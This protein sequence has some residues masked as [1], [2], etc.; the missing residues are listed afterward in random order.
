[1]LDVK[2]VILYTDV[3]LWALLAVVLLYVW[4]VRREPGLAAKWRRV[5]AGPHRRCERRAP[6]RLLSRGFGR[7]PA[8]ACGAP[9]RGRF[10]GR[11]L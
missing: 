3:V 11:R 8:L 6:L 5:L 10:G 9:G 1:M 2:P 7:Q 4:H